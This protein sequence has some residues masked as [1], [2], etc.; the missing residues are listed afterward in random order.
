MTDDDVA[1]VA[2]NPPL[3]LFV[4]LEAAFD[5]SIGGRHLG[6]LGSIILADVVFGIARRTPA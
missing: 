1:L 4:L 5:P 3:P 2:A 6:L